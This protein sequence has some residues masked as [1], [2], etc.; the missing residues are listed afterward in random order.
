MP[1]PMVSVVIPNYNYARFVGQ[2]IES[3]LAQTFTDF[4]IIVVDNGS[5]DNSLEVLKTFG[6]RI[7]VVA[8]ENRG[9]SGSRNRGIEESRGKLVAFLD[10]DDLWRPTKLEKQVPFFEDSKI[11][12]VYTGV[13]CVDANLKRTKLITPEFRGE[14]LDKFISGGAVIQGGESTAVIRKECFERLGVFDPGLSIC[15]GWDLY[16]RICGLYRVEL[17]AEPLMQY[18]VHGTN[19]HGRIDIFEHDVLLRLEKMFADPLAQ[20]IHARKDEAYA[21]SYLILSGSYFVAGQYAQALKF[22]ALALA[23][24]PSHSVRYIADLP[25]RYLRRLRT[26]AKA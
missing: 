1:S 24:K 6:R 26:R 9:Q 21:Q 16:R 22:G 14:L 5:T 18:R 19:A 13:E 3:V 25:L 10:A 17:V 15:A 8:Q 7:R 11:G 23:K 2:A 12:L 4:E 20:P